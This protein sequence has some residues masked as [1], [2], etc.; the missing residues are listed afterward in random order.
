MLFCLVANYDDTK[1]GKM[2]QRLAQD[3]NHDEL[4][5]KI[6]EEMLPQ[7]LKQ[8]DKNS[9][10]YNNKLAE[11]KNEIKLTLDSAIKG[12]TDEDIK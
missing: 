6:A 11:V 2:I 4:I 5:T 9:S 12:N 7:N 1:Y 10:E 3:L 8:A